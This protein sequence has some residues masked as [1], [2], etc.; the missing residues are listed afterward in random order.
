MKCK[1][2]TTLPIFII[3]AILGFGTE[4]TFYQ[5]GTRYDYNHSYH[6]LPIVSVW[7]AS[8]IGRG[9]LRSSSATPNIFM[10]K[11]EPIA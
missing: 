9:S 1:P 6:Y 7:V 5:V 11:G 4:C 2:A 10:R 8:T 3:F